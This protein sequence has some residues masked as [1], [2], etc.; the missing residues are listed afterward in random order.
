MVKLII[1]IIL[2]F[3]NNLTEAIN[4]FKEDPR[5]Y[6]FCCTIAQKMEIREELEFNFYDSD[7]SR[8]QEYKNSVAFYVPFSRN[9]Y[10]NKKYMIKKF[11]EKN[12][13][14]FLVL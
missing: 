8:Y 5:F 14:V 11:E 1:I 13:G 12:I 10:F 2:L 7:D 9:I 4:I 6:K 3:L